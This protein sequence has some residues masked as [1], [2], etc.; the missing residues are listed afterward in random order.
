MNKMKSTFPCCWI[1]CSLLT[2]VAT[3]FSTGGQGVFNVRDYG[4]KGDGNTLD[5]AAIQQAVNA[6][7]A[8]GGGQVRLPPGR[9]L[10]GTIRLHGNLTL[11]LDAGAMLTGATNL[12]LYSGFTLTNREPRLATSRWH[13]GLL[14]AE[15]ADNITIAGHGVINGNKVFDPRGEERMRGPHT[16]LL[17]HCKNFAIRDISIADSANYAI[18]FFFSDDIEVRNV[19][20][21]GGWDGVHFRGSPQRGCRNVSIIGCQFYTG[22]DSIAGS[23]WENVLIQNCVINSSCNG[24]RLIGPA[25]GLL[26][27]NC[28]FYGPGLHPH[29]TSNRTNM[30][31]AINLQPSGWEPMPGALDD[32]LLSDLTI[33]NVTTPFHIVLKKGNSGGT[34]RINRVSASGIYR[35]AASVENWSDLPLTN[36]VFRDVTMEFTGGGTAEQGRQPIRP[37]GVDARPLPAWAFYVRNVQQLVLDHVRVICEKPDMR[38]VMIADSVGQ[39]V[40][41]SFKFP[42]IDGVSQPLVLT[43]TAKVVRRE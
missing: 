30:L 12:E 27:Q 42:S 39:L 11:W 24:I 20:I 6:C 9:Y 21:T 18:L 36:V 40:F 10:S 22:D 13:R 1:G 28:L 41:E 8:A 32:V 29:R 43:N 4:A 19:K 16:I 23:Y 14:V 17:G 26:V 15:N 3:A 34:I 31:A 37:P 7:S 5:T 33:H 2:I 38:P 25:R 35:A